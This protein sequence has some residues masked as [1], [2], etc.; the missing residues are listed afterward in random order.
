MLGFSSWLKRLASPKSLVGHIDSADEVFVRGWAARRGTPQPIKVDLEADG[1][2]IAKGLIA[3]EF[4]TDLKKAGINE[5][6]HGFEARLNGTS[7]GWQT[8]RL[9]DSHSRKLIAFYDAPNRENQENHPESGETAQA[10][11]LDASDFKRMAEFFDPDYY[12]AQLDEEIEDASEL[13]RHYVDTGH[14]LGLDPSAQFET[15]YYLSTH[16]DVRDA[17]VNALWHFSVAGQ[18]EQR[19]TKRDR[20]WKSERLRSL[21]SLDEQISEWIKESQDADAATEITSEPEIKKALEA[22]GCVFSFLHADFL[23]NRGGIQLC[24]SHEA[25]QVGEAHIAIVPVQPLPV[26]AH[27]EK[28]YPVW[29]ICQKRKLG[30]V[31]MQRLIELVSDQPRDMSDARVLVHS[32]LGHRPESVVDLTNALGTEEVVFWLHDHSTLCPSYNLL[33]NNV[34]YCGAPPVDSD[35]CNVCVYGEVREEQI[36]R[37][38]TLFAKTKV[39]AIAPSDFQ[40]EFWQS[41]SELPVASIRSEPLATIADVIETH[42]RVSKTANIAFAGWPAPHKGWNEFL[43]L[44]EEFGHDEQFSFHVFSTNPKPLRGATVH[45]V[46]VTPDAPNAM[47]DA[48][49]E[50]EI[51]VVVHW[52][53]WPE[54]FSFVAHEA[55]AADCMLLTSGV[56]GNV[57]ALAATYPGILVLESEQALLEF[58]HS[59]EVLDKIG[60]NDDH[61]RKKRDLVLSQNAFSAKAVG[62]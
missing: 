26:L 42:D 3:G 48:L 59:Q 32:I 2:I 56:S 28:D 40:K 12:A 47:R 10:G 17:G 19:Q 15:N 31:S 5:G 41:R 44:L 22:E 57:N 49:F 52:T 55:L 33:R 11:S 30:P 7:N 51:D 1:K 62:E 54:T 38:R 37:I 58:F 8:L 4:R 23:E 13:L 21:Q 53:H 45:H 34:T 14:D 24:V 18:F 43:L 61:S 25:K 46:E 20:N 9:L 50:N 6:F 35:A 60:L 27:K 16:E 36:S 39:Q 29:L